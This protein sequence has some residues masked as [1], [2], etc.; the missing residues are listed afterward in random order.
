[1]PKGRGIMYAGLRF[2]LMLVALSLCVTPT[3]AQEK[4]VDKKAQPA[5]KAPK[6]AEPKK[7]DSVDKSAAPAAGKRMAEVCR[8]DGYLPADWKDYDGLWSDCVDPILQGQT[9]V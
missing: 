4:K 8:K 2:A 7:A 5:K 6:K 1:M 9:M 3:W